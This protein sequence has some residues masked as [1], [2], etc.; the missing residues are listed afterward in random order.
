VTNSTDRGPTILRGG[1]GWTAVSER[2]AAGG[3]TVEE[4][5]ANYWAMVK[6]AQRAE[7]TNQRGNA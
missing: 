6:N 4:A 3:R 2:L 7:T 5:L 1:D